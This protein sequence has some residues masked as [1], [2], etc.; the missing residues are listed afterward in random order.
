M[1]EAG[2]GEGG[3]PGVEALHIGEE[4]EEVGFELEGEE[5]GKGIVVPKDARGI[6]GECLKMLSFC[7]EYITVIRC[8]HRL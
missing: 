2:G 1:D 7:W 5:G 3:G 4:D 6:L 8:R